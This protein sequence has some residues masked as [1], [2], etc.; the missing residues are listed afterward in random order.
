MIIQKVIIPKNQLFAKVIIPRDNY[1]PN[2]Q[3][4]KVIV[5]INIP[6]YLFLKIIILRILFSNHYFQRWLFSGI[7]C[8]NNHSQNDYFEN[9][10]PQMIILKII[11]SRNT[12]FILPAGGA[13]HPTP[14]ARCARA[15]RALRA[16]AARA[17]RARCTRAAPQAGLRPASGRPP[18][19]PGPENIILTLTCG[20]LAPP[21]H[22]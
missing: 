22:S 4:A 21:P 7:L 6:K 13:P 16:R 18:A 10:Y 19:G 2:D 17:L 9:N 14:R 20:C 12:H 15:A 1:F 3:I 11:V 8:S 5:M